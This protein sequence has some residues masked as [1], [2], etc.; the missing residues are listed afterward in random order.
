MFL[1]KPTV[2]RPKMVM[3]SHRVPL[4]IL[5]QT[6]IGSEM[7]RLQI[8]TVS[9]RPMLALRLITVTVLGPNLVLKVTAHLRAS[10]SI[11][12]MIIHSWAALR[13]RMAL[14]MSLMSIGAVRLPL[15]AT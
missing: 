9:L 15:Q 13:P 4:L 8:L 7:S 14:H 2:T 5:P 6:L 11:T 1:G 3:L 12:L 10:M